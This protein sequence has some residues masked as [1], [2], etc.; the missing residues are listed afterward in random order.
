MFC[1]RVHA[2]CRSALID[3]PGPIS[4]YRLEGCDVLVSIRAEV[5]L[6]VVNRHAAIDIGGIMALGTQLSICVLRH[7]F[8]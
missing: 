1:Q 4:T 3:I 7:S 5:L 2:F 8:V 6:C